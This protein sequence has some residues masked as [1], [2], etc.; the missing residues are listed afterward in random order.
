MKLDYKKEFLENFQKKI[1]QGRRLLQSF[2]HRWADRLFTDTL[3]DIEKAEW[4]DIQ[5][6]HQLVMI[7]S[8]SW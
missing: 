2:N 1:I 4:L 7:I 5:K 3:F 8:N 6:K